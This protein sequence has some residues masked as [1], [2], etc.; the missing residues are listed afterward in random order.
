MEY[1]STGI[2]RYEI[3]RNGLKL[4]IFPSLHYSITPL[5]RFTETIISHN[6]LKIL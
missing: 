1:W 3:D 2:L 5:L 4:F 6:Y